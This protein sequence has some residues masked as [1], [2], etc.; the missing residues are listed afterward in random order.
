MVE[1]GHSKCL[2]LYYKDDEVT[3]WPGTLRFPIHG[4][5]TN[6]HNMGGVRTDFWF[7]GWDWDFMNHADPPVELLDQ[8]RKHADLLRGR[9]PLP[10]GKAVT[11]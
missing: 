11:S 8:A 4:M 1:K 7:N 6:R 10:D 2:P 3:N 9:A 5:K